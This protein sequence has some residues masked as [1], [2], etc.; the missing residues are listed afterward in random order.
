MIFSRFLAILHARNLEFIRDRSSLGW[1]VALPV[2]L[3]IG[4]GF[5][6]S[7]NDRELFKVGILDN[8]TPAAHTE[9]P[10]LET[11]HVDFI[12]ADDEAAAL[13]KVGRHQLDMLLDLR[14]TPRYWINTTSPRGYMLEKILHGTGGDKF[15]RRT[16]EREEVG[17]LDW[18]MP[19]I[20]GMNMMFSCLFGVGYVIVRYRKNGY[21]KRLHATP[22]LAIEFIGAQ[23]ASRLLLIM[24]ITIVVYLGVDL[25][26][27]FAMEG[28]YLLLLLVTA[29]GAMSMVSLGLLVAAR[30]ASEE[31]AGGLLN[32]L[33]WPMML[34][35]G[36]WFSLEGASPW[37]KYLAALFPL[38]HLLDA[39]RAV[40]IDGAGMAEIAE[41]LFI[42]GGMTVAF[43]AAGAAVFRWRAD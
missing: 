27:G 35:S 43:M 5:L 11:R 9:L 23:L 40:M 31:L 33:S 41:Q 3:V 15:E 30:V 22:L 24:A 6:F 17:Y 39:A 13:R 10:F 21:L 12:V 32:V 18:V 8:H 29:L 36:V 28:S 34:L 19:G 38:T 4:L 26:I 2:L 37:V 7:G 16:V 1:N 42:L 14:A 20:L 25:V